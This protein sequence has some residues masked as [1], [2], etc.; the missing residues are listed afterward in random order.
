MVPKL[1][2]LINRQI[3][4]FAKFRH[5]SQHEGPPVGG[6]ALQLPH[7]LSEPGKLL[8][9]VETLW[10]YHIR[11]SGHVLGGPLDCS[12]EALGRDPSSISPGTDDELTPRAPL[13]R[14]T[15]PLHLVCEG[16]NFHQ[17]L[18]VQVPT[19][20]GEYLVLDVQPSR[21]G[22]RIVL[23][24]LPHH[25][26]LPEAGVSI[27]NHGKVRHGHNLTDLSGEHIHGSDT[28][29]RQPHTRSQGRP[30]QVGPLEPMLSDQPTHQPVERSRQ[31]NAFLLHQSA[32]AGPH[33]ASSHSGTER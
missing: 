1:R 31:G 29:I 24:G 18:A 28:N 27:G 8:L 20:L 4:G 12:I 16:V 7:L 26:R 19:T 17:G 32:E 5:V 13:R 30:A 2:K 14:L 6:R 10:E 23:H 33:A 3:R 22:R 9:R 11:A 15:G 25:L 21:A